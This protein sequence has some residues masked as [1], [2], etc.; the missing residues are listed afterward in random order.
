MHLVHGDKQ[1]FFLAS[2]WLMVSGAKGVLRLDPLINFVTSWG[3]HLRT[4]GPITRL[5]AGSA[6][7]QPYIVT[8]SSSP[9]CSEY[10]FLLPLRAGLTMSSNTGI[11]FYAWRTCSGPNL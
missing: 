5:L 7:R 4:L 10:C 3:Q 2:H 8:P 11:V 6:S 1:N 9:V